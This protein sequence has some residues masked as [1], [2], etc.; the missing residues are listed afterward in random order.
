MGVD[1]DFA[2]VGRILG[3]V[4]GGS[5]IPEK[6]RQPETATWSL[7]DHAA[8]KRVLRARA[9]FSHE[10]IAAIGMLDV[11]NSLGSEAVVKARHNALRKTLLNIREIEGWLREDPILR[12]SISFHLDPRSAA[13]EALAELRAAA[14]KEIARLKK[15]G[16]YNVAILKDEKAAGYGGRP[17]FIS[18]LARIYK[19]A[20]GEEATIS[21]DSSREP[22][23][24]FLTFV[25]AIVDE[26]SLPSMTP[27]AIH[28]A[29]KRARAADKT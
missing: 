25:M 21:Q 14:S 10:I 12:S 6:Y 19:A 26:C 20:F 1:L 28:Q 4:T 13:F 3:A 29:W 11:V 2:A 24:R 18:G 22:T 8:N 23:G 9:E 7:E 16:L 17:G 27:A 15:L 5:A